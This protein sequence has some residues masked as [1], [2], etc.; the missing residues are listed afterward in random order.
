MAHG[1]KKVI[2][3]ALLGN[4]AIAVTKFVAAAVSGS[5]AMLSEGVHSLVDCGNQLLLLYG[6]K[7]AARPA[8]EK[9]PFGYGKE[10]YFWSFVVAIS[11]FGL[12][13]G[14]SLYEGIHHMLHPKPVASPWLSYLVLLASIGFEGYSCSVAVREF[15]KTKGQTGW[16]RAVRASKDP[17]IFVVLFEDLAAM[18]GLLVALAGITLGHVTGNP[19]Y[20]GAAAVGI[21]LILA[22]AAVFL[23]FETKG[24]LIGEAADP[25]VV[26]ALR[27]HAAARA[28]L[29]GITE[30]ATMHMGP[31]MILVTISADFQDAIPAG[32]V[33]EIICELDAAIKAEIPAV[34]RLYVQATKC[35]VPAEATNAG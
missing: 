13:A 3:A 19:Y 20:D 35:P 11:I 2:I 24:L 7:R 18:A 21:G 5:A 6:L 9:F 33:E 1:S 30:I 22:G 15:R 16:L 34:R 29:V 23:A 31:E 8:D 27:R 14:V 12:G 25:R 32:R 10:V 17:A 4:M 26:A 28:E